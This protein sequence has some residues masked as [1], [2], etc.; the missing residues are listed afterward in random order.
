MATLASAKTKYVS[1]SVQTM[2]PG[3]MIVALYDRMILDL[4]RAEAAIAAADIYGAHCAL[5]HAQDIVGALHTSLDTKQWP[6]GAQL[7]T[8]YRSIATEL[9]AANVTKDAARVRGCRDLLAPLRDAWRQAAGIALSE[10]PGA[11]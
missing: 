2:S 5:M 11:L 10:G 8:L 7:V 9:I 3:Q 4:D 6:G 1:D